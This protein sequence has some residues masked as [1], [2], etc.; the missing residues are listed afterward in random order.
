MSLSLG[1]SLQLPGDMLIGPRNDAAQIWENILHCFH[2]HK[3][4]S[5]RKTSAVY[6]QLGAFILLTLT[7]YILVILFVVILIFLV[8]K[9]DIFEISILVLISRKSHQLARL[10]GEFYFRSCART[11]A[12]ASPDKNISAQAHEK[13]KFHVQYLPLNLHP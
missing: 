6:K 11:Q 4:Q 7:N 10:Y 3:N 9:Y 1:T 8:E 12:R 5:K 13:K 2:T